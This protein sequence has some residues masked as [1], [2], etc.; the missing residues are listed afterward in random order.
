MEGGRGI[1]GGSVSSVWKAALLQR[2]FNTGDASVSASGFTRG[3]LSQSVL[4][5]RGGAAL[6]SLHSDFVGL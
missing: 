3:F 4:T 1:K 2:G 5:A 6:I